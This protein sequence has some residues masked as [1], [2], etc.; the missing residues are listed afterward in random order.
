MRVLLIFVSIFSENIYNFAWKKG[1][2][3]SRCLYHLYSLRTDKIWAYFSENTP[4]D[5]VSVRYVVFLNYSD[6]LCPFSVR[7]FTEYTGR[8]LDCRARS[9]LVM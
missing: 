4:F 8:K 6:T 5:D 1:L 3:G 7:F 2:I 9:F